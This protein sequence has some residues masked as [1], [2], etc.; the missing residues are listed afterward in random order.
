MDCPLVDEVQVFC[1]DSGASCGFVLCA[2]VV[3]LLVHLGSLGFE[4]L[5]EM[6]STGVRKDWQPGLGIWTQEANK[7][8]VVRDVLVDGGRF[9]AV[10]C[11]AVFVRAPLGVFSGVAA[12][13]VLGGHHDQFGARRFAG[14]LA[15]I[16]AV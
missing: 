2:V 14:Q 15:D 9:P 13:F 6:R 8:R 16:H 12:V 5:S 10:A 7:I 4:E 1:R 3:A 11:V